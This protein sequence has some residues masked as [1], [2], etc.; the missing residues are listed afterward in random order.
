MST[1]SPLTPTANDPAAGITGAASEVLHALST[2]ST[3]TAAELAVHLGLGRSTVDKALAALKTRGLAARIPAGAAHGSRPAARWA[4]TPALAAPRTRRNR[5]PSTGG[6]KAQA[7][8]GPGGDRP[9]LA[10]GQLREQVMA[11]L[12]AQPAGSRHTPGQIAKALGRS[13]GA[14][15]N[16]CGTLTAT[17]QAVLAS[18]KPR[19][20]TAAAAASPTRRRRAAGTT[21]PAATPASS[22]A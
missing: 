13:A 7:Q 21:D 1:P 20:Y 3:P 17:G 11:Y 22:D 12:H 15:A 8:A 18:D 5:Q 2:L 14:I 4:A 6:P 19:A 16:A 10:P 9:R